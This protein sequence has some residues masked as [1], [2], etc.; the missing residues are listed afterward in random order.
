MGIVQIWSFKQTLFKLETHN[1]MNAA[2]QLENAVKSYK[3]DVERWITN[4]L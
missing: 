2:T 1:Y 3:G 4:M